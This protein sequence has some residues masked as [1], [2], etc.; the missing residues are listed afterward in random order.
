MTTSYRQRFGLSGTPLAKGAQGES[1]F[2]ETAGYKRLER[3][4]AMLLEEPG[5]G[6]LTAEPGVGKTAAIRNLALALPRPQYRVV[7]VCDTAIGPLDAYRAL[8][9][10]LG[11]EPAFRRAA[12]W[13][14]LKERIVHMVD[15]HDEHPLLIVDEAQHLPDRFLVDFSGFLNFAFDSRDLFTTWLVGQPQ[16]R[17]RLRKQHYAALR[18]RI[19]SNVHLE[20]IGS[21]ED[22][23]EFL[24]HGLAAVGVKSSII[25]DSARELIY[26]ASGGLPREVGKLLRKALRLADERGQNFV[27]EPI[28]ESVLGEEVA[29]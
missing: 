6:V 27:D 13:R 24:E 15:E 21:R 26:R 7:Y 11:L 12:L 5:L 22:F 8:A 28:V 10:E 1:F 18:T 4:F 14:Q 3:N 19:V 20:P 17:A 23:T 29:L 2:A 9:L 25:A 16:L